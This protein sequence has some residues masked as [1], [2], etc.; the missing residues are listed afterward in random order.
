[1]KRF[2]D[3]I[4]QY[5]D[6]KLLHGFIIIRKSDLENVIRLMIEWNTE[7][8]RKMIELNNEELKLLQEQENRYS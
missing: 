7:V 5:P 1:M 2:L 3:S 8:D 4:P 6:Q